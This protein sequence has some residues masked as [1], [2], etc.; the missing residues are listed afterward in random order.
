MGICI[1]QVKRIRGKIS[2]RTH[3]LTQIPQPMHKNSEMNAI[4]SVGFT[5]I[6]SFPEQYRKRSSAVRPRTVAYIEQR[7][8]FHDRT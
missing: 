8:H 2:R 4:L 6:Q 5:S 1:L 3:F 7:T